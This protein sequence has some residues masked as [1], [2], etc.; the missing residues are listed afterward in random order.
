MSGSVFRCVI[1]ALCGAA[2]GADAA[3][4]DAGS[5]MIVVPAGAFPMGDDRGTPDQAPAH[6]VTLPAFRIDR[7]EATN[8]EIAAFLNAR[9]LKSPEGQ[10]YY[11]WDDRDARIHRV[12]G[13]FAPDPGYERHPA[14]EVSWFGAR[15]YCTW[16]GRRLPTEAEWEKAARGTD[17]RIYP[18]GNEPPDPSRAVYGRPYNDTLPVGSR[19]RGASPYGVEDMAGS[20]WEWTASQYRPYPY[21]PKNGRESSDPRSARVIRGGAHDDGPE[22]IKAT[23][24][25]AYGPDGSLGRGHHHVGVRCAADP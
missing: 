14:V 19:P 24:R 11:D 4:H 13:R 8:A 25:R 12:G 10:D 18:W 1:F 15:D 21:D 22:Q 16:R 23:T 2:L 20:L 6:R 17:G 7:F 5:T 3:N 9:G